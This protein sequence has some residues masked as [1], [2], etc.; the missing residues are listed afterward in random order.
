MFCLLNLINTWSWRNDTFLPN[1]LTNESSHWIHVAEHPLAMC[2]TSFTVHNISL[3]YTVFSRPPSLC[4]LDLSD[5]MFYKKYRGDLKNQAARIFHLSPVLV[6]AVL[7]CLFE[8]WS[9][10]EIFWRHLTQQHSYSYDFWKVLFLHFALILICGPLAKSFINRFRIWRHYLILV[11]L[12]HSFSV[13]SLFISALLSQFLNADRS[14][15]LAL[16]FSR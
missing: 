5:H 7:C 4:T 1:W 8:S 6:L 11:V 3:F 13:V 14:S 10:T 15:I 16:F 9:V 2:E 12:F